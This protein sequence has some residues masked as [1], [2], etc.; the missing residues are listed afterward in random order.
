MSAG[1]VLLE[2]AGRAVVLGFLV[3][4]VVFLAFAVLPLDPARSLLGPMA[5]TEAVATLNARYG[6]DLPIPARLARVTMEMLQGNFGE[7]L[8]Y[9]EPV[10]PLVGSALAKTLLRLALALLLGFVGARLLVPAIVSAGF[11]GSRHALAAVAGVPSFVLLA[12]LLMIFS[13]GFGLST[14]L[15]PLLYNLLAICV[16]ALVVF[17]TIALTIYDRVDYKTSPSRPA[18]FLLM[19]HAPADRL[20]LI[21]LRGA[22]PAALAAL[23]NSVAP[24]L[25]ALTFAEFVFGLDG[26]S[27]MFMRAC[28][29][30]DMAV[31]AFGSFIVALVLVVVQSAVSIGSKLADRRLA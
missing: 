11:S 16:A 28:S 18:L 4:L 10:V 31:V 23:A 3:Y 24:A 6:F 15:N 7:S 12:L 8:T 14:F 22:M 5:S 21:L 25:T 19:L 29:Y 30:G 2:I 1:R 26:F 13:A 27:L 17:A 9:G 20:V